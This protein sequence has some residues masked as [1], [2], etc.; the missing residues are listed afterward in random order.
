MRPDR[1][2][3]RVRIG[4]QAVVDL[5]LL[6][7]GD[8]EHHGPRDIE[9]VGSAHDDAELAARSDYKAAIDS[10]K[11]AIELQGGDSPLDC[12]VLA[13]ANWRLENVEQARQW[14]QKAA[15]RPDD[16]RVTSR[17]H[18]EAASLLGIP[19]ATPTGQERT[20]NSEN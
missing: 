5:D 16:S 17:F 9:H 10:I 11:R 4:K 7:G 12:Y 3:E 2:R 13:M 20:E 1:P 6:A 19:L 18:A 14:Y 8:I 15:A